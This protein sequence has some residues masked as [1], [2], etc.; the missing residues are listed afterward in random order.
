MRRLIGS[1]NHGSTACA[2]TSL[3]STAVDRNRQVIS[4]SGDGGRIVDRKTEPGAI[5]VIVFSNGALAL[6][7]LAMKASGYVNLGTDLEGPDFVQL[8]SSCDLFGL[9]VSRASELR[10]AMTKFLVHG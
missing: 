2:A 6:V 10:A 4:M 3:W 5:K 7:K 8:A 9:C 1:F